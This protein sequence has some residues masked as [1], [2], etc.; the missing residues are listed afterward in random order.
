M[1]RFIIA[2][3]LAA[4]AATATP[5]RLE[6]LEVRPSFFV[7][8]GAGANV[9]VQVGEDGIVVVDAGIGCRRAGRAGCDQAHLA[10]AHSLRHRH[11]S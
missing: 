9:G 2:I 8:A 3:F 5:D 7:I 11:G 4:Q 10:E 1:V 6:V